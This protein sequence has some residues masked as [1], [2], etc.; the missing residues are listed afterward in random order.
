MS[1][2]IITIYVP[3]AFQRIYHNPLILQHVDKAQLLVRL[4]RFCAVSDIR[5]CSSSQCHVY[6]VSLGLLNLR[7][8]GVSQ[9][10]LEESE[11]D[12]LH[13][14]INNSQKYKKNVITG[15]QP[16]WMVA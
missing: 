11:G 6:T 13:S 14:S 10:L 8:T 7:A 4:E 1:N 15:F 2:D 3:R 12:P 5:I 16:R 9:I